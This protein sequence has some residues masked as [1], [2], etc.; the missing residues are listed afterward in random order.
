MGDD[1][2]MKES[3]LWEVLFGKKR[4]MVLK[5][6]AGKARDEAKESCRQAEPGEGD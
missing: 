3:F 2:G 6:I 4:H 1:E 5:D